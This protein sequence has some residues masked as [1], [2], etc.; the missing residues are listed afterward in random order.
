MMN[1]RPFKVNGSDEGELFP[2]MKAES[3][4]G[5]R[6]RIGRNAP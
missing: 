4:M 3:D 2:H 6:F 1:T 5:K